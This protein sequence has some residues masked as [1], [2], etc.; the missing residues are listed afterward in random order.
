LGTVVEE[1]DETLFWLDLLAEAQIVPR[2][3]LQELLTEANEIVSIFVVS[4]ST[5]RKRTKD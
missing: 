3:R 4:R 2:A 5:A 1:A